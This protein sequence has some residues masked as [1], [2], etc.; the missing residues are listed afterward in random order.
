[1]FKYMVASPCS[2]CRMLGKAG[3][4]KEAVQHAM[5]RHRRSPSNLILMFL[6][7]FGI[8]QASVYLVW[9]YVLLLAVGSLWHVLRARGKS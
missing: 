7:L 4:D 9:S 2:K 3:N 1:M 6:S 5:V 8:G